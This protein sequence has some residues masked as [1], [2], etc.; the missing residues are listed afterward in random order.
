MRFESCIGQDFVISHLKNGVA[1]QRVAHAQLFV[2][3]CG[4]GILPLA[5]AYAR[6][7]VCDL[8]DSGK[9]S[10]C[11]IKFDHL[12]H[13][14]LHFVYPVSNTAEVKK[15]AVSDHFATEWR[16][17]L[18]INPYADLLAWHRHLGIEKKQAKIGVDEAQDVL[19]KLSLKSY[20]GGRKV[21]IVWM[22]E[23][24]NQEASNKL[25]KLIEEPPEKTVMLLLTESEEQIIDT[26]RSRCQT[27]HIPVLGEDPIRN[28]LIKQEGCTEAI[29]QKIAHQSQGSYDRALHLLHH[30][31]QEDEFEAWFVDWVRTAFRAKG[32]KKAILDLLAW[33]ETIA[34]KGRETQKNFL[35]FCDDFFRQALLLNYKASSLVYLKTQK[36]FELSKFAP[37]IHGNNIEGISNAIQDAAYHVERNA[38]G[39][40]VFSDLSIKLTRLL[41]QKQ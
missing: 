7:L 37:F 5:I 35:V 14:D 21:I 6:N 22:A 10:A 26:I 28:A 20:E 8:E 30:D 33:S 29:A 25:L 39:K 17:F 15:H 18:K 41:H 4:S 16:S 11:N 32:N 40:I 31:G 38:S 36:G 24:L 12:S 27:L 19:R 23:K 3:K 9:Q 1:N 2:G 13:P 34:S